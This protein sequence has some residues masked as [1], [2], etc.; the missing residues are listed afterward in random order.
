MGGRDVLCVFSKL[1]KT[2]GSEIFE[3]DK[4]IISD[5]DSILQHDLLSEIHKP[6]RTLNAAWLTRNIRGIATTEKSRGWKRRLS[7]FLIFELMDWFLVIGG[8]LWDIG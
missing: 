1:R 8:V 2:I 7:C 3:E 4:K 5:L 6:C